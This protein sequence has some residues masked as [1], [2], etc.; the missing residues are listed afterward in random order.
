MAMEAE[1]TPALFLEI[2]PVSCADG[3]R[4][5]LFVGRAGAALAPAELGGFFVDKDGDGDDFGAMLIPFVWIPGGTGL[6]TLAVTGNVGGWIAVTT[7]AILPDH[8]A[9]P[10]VATFETFPV[11]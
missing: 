9:R 1:R 10:Q 5:V 6:L 8:E 2:R 7:G 4:R 11:N 3:S